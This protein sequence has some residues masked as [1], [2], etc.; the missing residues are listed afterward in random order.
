MLVSDASPAGGMVKAGHEPETTPDISMDLLRH[1]DRFVDRH[2]GPRPDETL[3]ML[4][5]LGY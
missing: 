4:E 3:R 1:T 2:I 5:T